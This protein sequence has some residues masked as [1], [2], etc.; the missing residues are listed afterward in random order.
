MQSPYTGRGR[1]VPPR[2]VG[3]TVPARR[4]YAFT[5]SKWR[6]QRERALNEWLAPRKPGPKPQ[7]PNPLE[8]RVAQLEKEKAQLE[9]RL[10]QV[11]SIT[12]LQ[13]KR[14]DPGCSSESAREREQL[15]IAAAVELSE[16]TSVVAACEVLGV[17]CVTFYRP[18]SRKAKPHSGCKKPARTRPEEQWIQ[19]L[20]VVHDERFV[21]KAPAEVYA[22][23][24]DERTY[25]CSIHTNQRGAGA[26]QPTATPC[27]CAARDAGHRAR[28]SLVV[29]YLLLR[30][31]EK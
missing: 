30:G 3:S 27:L 18:C 2:R 8:D 25:Y 16:R 17:S 11:E 4:I 22:A 9:R 26:G 23:L 10:K 6:K 20:D 7:E 19:V 24:L 21:N 14:R 31:P 29:G 28:P 1:S 13:K 12:E 15:L 5:V